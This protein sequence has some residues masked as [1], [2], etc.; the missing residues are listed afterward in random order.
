MPS[1]SARGACRASRR[2]GRRRA[3]AAVL[4]VVTLVGVSCGGSADPPAAPSAL[5][6]IGAGLQGPPGFVATVYA[7][8]LTNVAAFA[9]DPQGRLWAATAGA[10]DHGTDG[11]YLVPAP[12]AAPREVVASLHTPLGL[13]WYDGSLYAASSGGVDAF[14]GFD[15]TTFAERRT[16]LRLPA[17][18]G[19]LNGLAIGPDGRLLL[20]ISAPCDHCAPASRLSAAIVSFLPD[21]SGLELYATGIRA[22]VGLV[23]DGAAGGLVVTI[24]QRDD[25]GARTPGDWLAV[26]RPGQAWG[27]PA[28]YGQGGAVCAGVPTPTAVLDRHAGVIGLAIV[29]GQ[30][31]AKVGTSALV[32]EWALGKVQRVV[33]SGASVGAVVPFLLGLEHPGPLIVT[34]GGALLAGDWETGMIYRVSPA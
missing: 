6:S 13:L 5:V 29:D 10:S 25:L 26:V 3:V 33:L 7:R 28:C 23:E 9:F 22:P 20:G 1:D 11:L 30:F 17:G 4:G 16:V 8:G 18:A 24:D 31:G 27:F 32:A 12:G 2:A 19:E 14:I 15:G 34:P 21:G